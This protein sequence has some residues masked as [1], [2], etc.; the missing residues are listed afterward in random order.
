[1]R[2]LADFG[3]SSLLSQDITQI[4]GEPPEDFD[5]SVRYGGD[6]VGDMP[7]KVSDSH[8]SPSKLFKCN[9]SIQKIVARCNGVEY[10]VY[11]EVG[12]CF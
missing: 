11:E 4:T 9:F 2:I 10:L 12:S 3:L 7:D 1:M 5:V 6:G 8:S